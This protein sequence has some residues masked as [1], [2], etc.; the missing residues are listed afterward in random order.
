LKDIQSRFRLSDENDAAVLVSELERSGLIHRN[1]GD[2]TIAHAYPFSA[3]PTA[4]Q[5]Q[6]SDGPKV[7]AMCAIDAVGMPYMLKRDATVT[8]VCE[9]CGSSVTI[10]FEGQR[11]IES[12]PP[13]IVIW[14]ATMSEGCIL[15][16]DLCP[17]L[18]FFCS[19]DHLKAWQM[20]HPSGRGRM[21]TLVQAVEQG[22]RSFENLMQS[23]ELRLDS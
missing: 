11:L 10:R 7:Y 21:L 19:D 13:G 18:N 8:S 6:L 4:H 17:D 23:N 20:N 2:P 15:A 1:E 22:P 5:V 14:Y 16:T 3:E 12:A 9:S